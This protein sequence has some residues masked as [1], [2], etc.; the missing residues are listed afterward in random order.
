MNLCNFENCM[1]KK[2]LTQGFDC[3]EGDC[4]LSVEKAETRTYAAQVLDNELYNV[5]VRLDEREDIVSSRCDCPEAG[6]LYCKHQAAVFFTLQDIVNDAGA[7]DVPKRKRFS[8][9]RKILFKRT[10]DELIL[11]LVKLSSESKE[12]RQRIELDFDSDDDADEIHKS[13]MLMRTCITNHSDRYGF[14]AYENIDGAIKGADLVLKKAESAL[15]DDRLEHALDLLLCVIH[16]MIDLL[17]NA[18]DADGTI[19]GTVEEALTFVRETIGG[20]DPIVKARI[21]QKLTEEAAHRR[22]DDR[23]DWRLDLLHICSNIADAPALRAD[24]ESRLKALLKEAGDDWNADYLAEKVNAIRYNAIM[25]YDGPKEAQSFIERNLRYAEFRRIAIENALRRG[26]YDEVIRLAD[27][28]EEQDRHMPGLANRWKAY[29]RQAFRLSGK[30][31]DLRELAF[32]SVLNGSFKH[33][34]ELKNDCDAS[35][36]ASVYPK[37]ISS[38]KRQKK[39]HQD[40]YGRILIE[41][42]ETRKLLAHVEA[43]PS[44]VES[45]YKYLLPEFK[46]DV[47]ELFLRHIGQFAD[48]ASDREDYKKVCSLI[49]NLRKIGGKDQAA[50]IKQKLFREYVRKPAFREE[51]SKL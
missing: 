5:E 41:E 48:Q 7:G 32:E 16:E 1:D 6:G 23:N 38:L 50:E 45:F 9:M 29:R 12:I 22:Y 21:F 13:V 10:K 46:E 17:G 34:Q 49:R 8:D 19:G 4:V 30:P 31:D 11:L 44:R 51:L 35:E 18:D 47:C 43:E 25:R 2:I 15:K 42:G 14:V 39:T 26:D 3:Y 27:A 37:I 20:S 36:W 28:G 24:L 40:V 33:Y